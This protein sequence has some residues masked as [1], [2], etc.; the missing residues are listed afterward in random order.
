[1]NM[2]NQA[3]ST[4]NAFDPAASVFVSANAGAGKTS[5]LTSR[6]LSLLLH[7]VAPSKILCLTYTKAAAGEMANRVLATLGDWVMDDEETLAK[8]L[9][10][11]LGGAPDVRLIARSRTLFAKVLEAPE[12]LRIQTIHGFCQSLLGRFPIEAGVSPHFSV[13]DSRTEQELLA[14]ARTRLFNHARRGDSALAAALHRLAHRQS[15]FSFNKLISEII[16]QKRRFI[17]LMHAGGMDAAIGDVWRALGTKKEASF[18]VLAADF[19]YD[20]NTLSALRSALAALSQCS[21]KYDQQTATSLATW[22]ENPK[23]T[24]LRDY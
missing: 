21:G 11:I 5:M 7:G 16:A 14:Q 2:K 19:I 3:I 24:N 6:V 18:D 12:G 17:S 10:E 4:H 13:V 23:P 22:L 9:A 15:E 20:A 8:K 1:M